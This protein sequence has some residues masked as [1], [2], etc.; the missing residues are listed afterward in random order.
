MG[1]FGRLNGLLVELHPFEKATQ[2]HQEGAELSSDE[3]YAQTDSE[4]RSATAEIPLPSQTPA[5]RSKCLAASSKL[6]LPKVPKISHGVRAQRLRS[7][8]KVTANE[9]YCPTCRAWRFFQKRHWRF[10]CKTC[11]WFI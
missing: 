8:P 11:K 6:D 1:R 7:A 3:L 10:Q 9:K 4:Q 5:E 2:G